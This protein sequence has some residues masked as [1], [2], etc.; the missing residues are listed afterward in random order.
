MPNSG[1]LPE[2]AAPLAVSRIGTS[3]ATAALLRAYRSML[4]IRRIEERIAERYA[5]QEM[6][7]PVHLSIGQEAAAVGACLAL[8]T[9]DQI[10]STHRCHGHYLAK[11]GDLKAMVAEIYGRATGCC[12]GRGGSMHLFDDAAGVLCS[13]PIVGSSIALGIGAALH[14]KQTGQAQVCVVFLGDGALEEGVFHEA[15]NLAVVHDL[16][17][18]FFVENNLYSVY[19][20]LRE[21]Q[22]ARPL[23]ELGAAHAMPTLEADGNDV[24]AVHRVSQEAA[25]RARRGGGPTM[26]VVDTYRYREH[27]GPSY[28]DDLGYRPAGELASFEARCP[29]RRL[30][31]ELAAQHGF[32]AEQDLA[33]ERELSSE[34]ADAFEAARNAPFPAKSSVAERVY[35]APALRAVTA[36]PLGNAVSAEPRVISAAAAIHE[37]TVQAM[38]ADRRV[39]VLGEG[40]N[41]PKAIFGT[42]ANLAKEF[43]AGRCLEMPLAENGFTGMAVGAAVLGTRPIVIHQR[44]EFALL[45][46]EQLA[47]NAAKLHYVSNGQ[48]R[49]PLV[50]RLIVGRGWGQGPAHSQSLEALFAYLPGLKVVMPSSAADAKRLLLASIADEN[51]VIFIEHRWV[52]YATGHVPEIMPIETLDGPRCIRE[53]KDIT[54]VASSYMTLEALQAAEALAKHGCSVDL[55]DLRVISP[56]RHELIAE[57]VRR[58]GRLL[59]LDTG[60]ADFGVGAEICA[61]I[62]RECWS[63]LKGAPERLGLPAHPTPSSPALAERYYARSPQIAEAIGQSVGLGAEAMQSLSA[64]LTAERDRLPCDIPHPAFKG[65][66]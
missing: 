26:I 40:V 3:S 37:A 39:I 28:D 44:V 30:R 11:G 19:T 46:L 34:I 52:H 61:R 45:A 57:S 14:F 48:H 47:N 41:D 29:I 42:T 66:F 17:V 64:E 7:C 4:R 63:S 23:T 20:Q 38:R 18:V 2:P 65:P 32:T 36:P 49:V 56:L 27:C 35:A 13:V 31:D 10:V 53:G 62:T 43:G 50:V 5:Q 15:A 60:Y 16:P 1:A 21:R 9:A 12:G 58:T 22:P 24:V 33:M 6:R 55:I 54:V 25:D 8:E 59:V 51:P